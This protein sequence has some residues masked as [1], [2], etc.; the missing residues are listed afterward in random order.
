M[1]RKIGGRE[2]IISPDGVRYSDFKRLI[3]KYPDMKDIANWTIEK[4][5]EFTLDAL[6]MLLPR[7][8]FFKP[9]IFKAIMKR[10]IRV[11]ELAELRDEVSGLILGDGIGGDNEGN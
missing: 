11:K 3:K 10:K 7:G 6:W 5:N 8:L 2:I 4:F 1:K 9:F